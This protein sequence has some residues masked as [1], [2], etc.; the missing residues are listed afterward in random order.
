MKKTVSILGCGWLGIQLGKNLLSEGY[1]VYGSTTTPSRIFELAEAEI[2]PVFINIEPGI[3]SMGSEAFFDTDAL[4][5]SLPPGR[6]SNVETYYPGQIAE[7]IRL[8]NNYHISRVLFISSTSVYGAVNKE[9]R[10]GEEGEPEKPSGRALLKAENLLLAETS[11]LTT[12]VRFAGLIGPGR[13]PARFFAGKSNV[14]GKVPVNLIHSTDCVNILT[15][16]ITD[17]IWGEVFNA[18]SPEHPLRE[19]IYRKASEASGL[20]LPEFTNEP[21]NYKIINSDKLQKQLNYSFKY[22]NP[23]DCIRKISV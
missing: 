1:N 3:V 8:L 9:V 12:V 19:E 4:V 2:K 5:I 13:N 6:S 21:Q 15:K 11:F 14:P 17:N 16:I 10:E 18:C 23:K 20:P 22:P 7:I